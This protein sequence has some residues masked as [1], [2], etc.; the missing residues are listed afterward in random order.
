MT[1]LADI[2]P[3]IHLYAVLAAAATLMVTHPAALTCVAFLIAWIHVA[4]RV[5][6]AVQAS[7]PLYSQSHAYT[8]DL[9]IHSAVLVVFL[10][11]GLR[12]YIRAREKARE[13]AAERNRFRATLGY[14]LG[15]V[16]PPASP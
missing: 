6:D 16:S 9:R 7:L 1:E 14:L 3:P 15:R 12:S 10:I 11:A 4:L 8:W 2:F 13:A 5:F